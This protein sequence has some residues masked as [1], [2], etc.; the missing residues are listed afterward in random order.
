MVWLL[1]STSD[2]LKTPTWKQEMKKYRV[3]ETNVSQAQNFHSRTKTCE[4]IWRANLSMVW[5][6]HDGILHAVLMILQLIL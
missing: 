4:K 5:Q 6:V 1:E 2:L 3:Y